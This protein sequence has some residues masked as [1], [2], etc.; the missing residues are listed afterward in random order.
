MNGNSAM[1]ELGVVITEVDFDRLK[2]LLESPRY[3]ATHPVLLRTLKA[4]LDRSAVVAPND[5]PKAS[6]HAPRVRAGRGD[7]ESKTYTLCTRRGRP[8]RG[9]ASAWRPGHRIAGGAVGQVVSSTP[10]PGRP[11]E[12]ESCCSSRGAGLHFY[13]TPE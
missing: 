12:V 7:C 1:Q 11:A 8:P 4:E 9:N 5:V 10:P 3:R 6:D 2:H 13:D